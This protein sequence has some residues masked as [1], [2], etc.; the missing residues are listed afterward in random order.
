MNNYPP[1]HSLV[2]VTFIDGKVKTY[3][4]TAGAGIAR[5]LAQDSGAT[6]TLTLLNGDEAYGIPVAQIREY[7]VRQIP[8]PDVDIQEGVA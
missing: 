3:S 6:G 4:M 5:Y 1:Q 2:E 8:Q 7:V